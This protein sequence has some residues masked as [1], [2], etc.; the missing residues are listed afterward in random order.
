MAP[1]PLLSWET[2]VSVVCLCQP[3]ISPQASPHS[4]TTSSTTNVK[5]KDGNVCHNDSASSHPQRP[6][7]FRL[8]LFSIWGCT[9]TP[10]Q[11]WSQSFMRRG[12][13][14]GVSLFFTPHRPLRCGYRW[15]NWELG[16]WS[17]FV[18]ITLQESSRVQIQIQAVTVRKYVYTRQWQSWA[19]S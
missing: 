15:E 8:Q 13:E 9:N 3:I 6:G 16:K 17:T 1:V 4:R 18:E 10:W 11:P 2:S 7:H 12:G 5:W 19:P 14:Y